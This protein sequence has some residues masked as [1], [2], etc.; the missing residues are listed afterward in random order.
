MAKLPT[1]H[2]AETMEWFVR[3]IT[4]GRSGGKPKDMKNFFPGMGAVDKSVGKVPSVEASKAK[5]LQK[6]LAEGKFNP[7]AAKASAGKEAAKKAARSGGK[8][9][10]AAGETIS[11]TDDMTW[12]G[13]FF[14][15][16]GGM[17]KVGKFMSG[18]SGV[19]LDAVLF[20]LYLMNMQE[21]LMESGFARQAEENVIE[22]REDVLTPQHF[23]LQSALPE[24]QER[25]RGLR[26]AVVGRLATGGV[27]GP[28][29]ARGETMIG[30]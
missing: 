27:L 12:L 21:K 25:E 17:S 10:K 1:K 15:K 7:S 30:S 8:F 3:A 16:G 2:N 5:R 29:L 9:T 19:A 14:G 20:G 24:A 23:Y 22:S 6:M 28:S 26:Q 11:K 18:K 13:K 4:E